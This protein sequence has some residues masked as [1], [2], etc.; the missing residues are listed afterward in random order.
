MRVTEEKGPSRTSGSDEP[1]K[2]GLHG[3]TARSYGRWR[4][5][6]AV[7]AALLAPLHRDEPGDDRRDD[8]RGCLVRIA[9]GPVRDDAGGGGTAPSGAQPGGDGRQHGGLD[10]RVDARPARHPWSRSIEMGG[11]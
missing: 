1:W 5:S 7:A 3:A 11:A 2:G 6:K 10:G 8:G 9:A 4:R